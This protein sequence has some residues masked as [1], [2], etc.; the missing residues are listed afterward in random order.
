MAL[1]GTPA[2]AA[3]DNKSCDTKRKIFTVNESLPSLTRKVERHEPIRILAIGSSSTEG[4]GASSPDH[5]Y[6]A[7]LEDELGESWK[8]GVTVVNAGRGGETAIETIDRL[9][10]ALKAQSYDL[11]IWQ[12]GTND[13]IRGVNEEAFRALLDR[14]IS[15]VKAAG[16][17]LILLDQQYFPTIKDMGRYER[18]VQ[19]VSALGLE[20]K[21]SVF[22]RYALMQDWNSRSAEE[23]RSMLSADG[24]HMSDKGYDCL[25]NHVA[26]A[27]ET[28]AEQPV[29]QTTGAGATQLATAR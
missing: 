19:T 6:P 7:Q 11:V 8:D 3:S 12:V 15:A 23:L 18:F 24:F 28:L 20:R 21:V 26:D 1:L 4:I 10:A 13:A 17:G 2:S 14:G 5:A 27:I 29:A 22:S 9:E 25:A 16:T